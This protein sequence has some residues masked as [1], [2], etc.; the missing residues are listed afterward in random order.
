M[1]VLIVDDSAFARERIARLVTAAG[2]EAIQAAGGAQALQLAAEMPPDAVTV[3]LLMP[4]MDGVELIRR[5]RAAY[6][7]LPLIVV[8]ADIQEATRRE[9]RA[10]GATAFVSKSGRLMPLLEILEGL[11]NVQKPSFVLTLLE[12]DAFTEMMNLAMG[13][14]ANALASLLERR[15]LLTAPKVEIMRLSAL[16][17]FLERNIPAIAAYIRQHFQGQLTG[18]AALLLPAGHAD[19]LVRA[20]INSIELSMSGLTGIELSALAEIG[21]VVLNAA[22]ARLGDQLGARLAI[23]QPT[24]RINLSAQMF[25]EDLSI[26]P[27]NADHAI[28]LLNRLTIG[29]VSIMCYLIIALSEADIRR[30]LASLGVEA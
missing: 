4:D 8:S 9:V 1:R 26:G 27:V 20:A 29:D 13:Q 24:V 17:V 19:L 11:P 15:V 16:R 7:D 10:A 21:N 6:P 3:D 25:V 23:G 30:L 5:L 2:H 12:Q 22:I 28:I 14:A 18:D